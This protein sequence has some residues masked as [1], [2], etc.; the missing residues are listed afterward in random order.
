[1]QQAV[2]GSQFVG[3]GTTFL[4]IVWHFL[5]LPCQGNKNFHS[6]PVDVALPS[7]P[8][9][10]HLRTKSSDTSARETGQAAGPAKGSARRGARLHRDGDGEL[11]HIAV[12][13]CSTRAGSCLFLV[14][15]D[16]GTCG[17]AL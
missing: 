6:M 12:C 8:G 7:P 15:F 2:C 10:L 11:K 13:S 16:N 3:P 1:M 17:S 4:R 14:Y 5:A 9:S